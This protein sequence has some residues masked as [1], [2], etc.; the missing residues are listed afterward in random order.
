MHIGE[1][2]ENCFELEANGKKLE[3]VTDILYLGDI[4]CNSGTNEKNIKSLLGKGLGIINNI[5]NILYT[6]NS[7]SSY[8]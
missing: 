2:A 6:E 1:K 3:E 8:F 5:L 7:G 4:V